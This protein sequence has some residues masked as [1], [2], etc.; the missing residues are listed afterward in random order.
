LIHNVI[1]ARPLRVESGADVKAAEFMNHMHNH[2]FLESVCN[3]WLDRNFNRITDKGEVKSY[4]GQ[5]LEWLGVNYYTRLVVKGR[6]SRLAKLFAGIPVIPELVENYGFGC[7]P[8]STSVEGRL[9][10]DS[11]WEIYPEGMLEALKLMGRYGKPLYITENGTADANDALRPKFLMDHLKILDRAI[12]E[13]KVDV[14]GY[15]HWSLTDNYEWT[16]GF[17]MKF[18]LYSVDLKTK[19]R[20]IREST[21]TFRE[22]IEGKRWRRD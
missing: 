7:K 14:R 12:N 20:R 22:I 10:S 13:E 15:F 21:K 11:G 2:F 18:G 17:S 9:T 8:N 1:P 5:R 3:G 4:I 16:R 6:K 19:M